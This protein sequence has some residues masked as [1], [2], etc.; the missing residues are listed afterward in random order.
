MDLHHKKTVFRDKRLKQY[1]QAVT[2]PGVIW[3]LLQILDSI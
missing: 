3:S 2:L 1:F